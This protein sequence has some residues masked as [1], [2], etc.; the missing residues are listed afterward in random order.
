MGFHFYLRGMDGHISKG[1]ALPLLQVL[2]I[3]VEIY[4]VDM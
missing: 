1:D 2:E 3:D 4:V